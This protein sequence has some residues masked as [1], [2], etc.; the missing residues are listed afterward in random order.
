MDG[1]IQMTE[2]KDCSDIDTAPK[3]DCVVSVL[4]STN[5]DTF[6]IIVTARPGKYREQTVAWLDSNCIP[7]DEILMREDGDERADHLVKLDLYRTYVEDKYRVL[8]SFDDSDEDIAMWRLLEI[9]T[10]KV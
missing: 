5:D 9:P 2:A 3:N 4:R 10:F 7:Y 8:G 1:T 6:T